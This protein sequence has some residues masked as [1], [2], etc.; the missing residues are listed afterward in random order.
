MG[1]KG[2]RNRLTFFNK[3][4]LCTAPVK[5]NFFY[6]DLI[7]SFPKFGKTKQNRDPENL[8]CEHF[9][10]PMYTNFESIV[11][12]LSANCLSLYLSVFGYIIDP[13]AYFGTPSP[14]RL[15]F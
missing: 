7:K 3:E 1:R 9:C 4:S 8:I 14:L 13:S 15:I 11:L 12:H 5:I 2:A 10:I 6:Y